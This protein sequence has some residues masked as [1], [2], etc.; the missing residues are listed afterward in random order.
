M[1]YNLI[2]VDDEDWILNGIQSAINWEKIGFFVAG[3]FTNGRD[4]LE[5]I[6]K[7][8]PDAILTDIKMPIQDGISLVKEIRAKELNQIEV[9][10]L[11]GYDDFNLAQA[12]L[13]LQAVDYVLKPSAPEQ[14]IEVFSRIKNKLDARRKSEEEKQATSEL[15][16]AGIKVIREEI[17][18]SIISSNTSKYN[19]FIDLYREFANSEK[20]LKF[21][22]CSVAFS[23]TIKEEQPTF[24][25]LQGIDFL[26]KCMK[27]YPV[28]FLKEELRGKNIY[29]NGNLFTI[30]I[31]FINYTKEE[32]ITCIEDIKRKAYV[33]GF[34]GLVCLLSEEYADFYRLKTVYEESLDKLFYLGMPEKIRHLYLN[35]GNDMVLKAAIADKDQEIVLWSLKNWFHEIDNA[36]GSFQWRLTRKLVYSLGIFFL[37]NGISEDAIGRLYEILDKRDNKKVKET[38]ISFVKV[39]LLADDKFKGRNAHLCKEVAKFIGNN[40]AED[41][42]LN[43]LADKF[44]ISPNYLGTLFKKNMGMGIKEYLTTVRLEQADVLITIGKFKLYQ[45]AQMVGYPN[46]EYF[47]KI[48]YKYKGKNPSE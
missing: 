41:I 18:N 46:Y 47:R 33:E 23:E 45:V 8:P 11:S 1:L 10:F 32:A 44:Y 27:E 20:K 39:E 37:Q 7:N 9:V 26:G 34:H 25:S 15:A 5:Y 14:I 24:H 31:L 12:S 2:L 42:S 13:R 3:T 19:K 16:Q 17:F 30:T 28:C 22:I 4:A 40:Y 36:Y 35:I 38:V 21:M 48:Y 29:F 6:L 43:E